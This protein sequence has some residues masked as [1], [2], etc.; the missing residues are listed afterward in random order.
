MQN[1]D[2]R[3]LNIIILHQSFM[4]AFCDGHENIAG[5]I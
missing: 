1:A 5:N 3:Y 2:I 4:S